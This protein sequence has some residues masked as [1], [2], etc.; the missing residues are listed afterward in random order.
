MAKQNFDFEKLEDNTSIFED[1]L[2]RLD[3]DSF[4][5]SKKSNKEQKD[6]KEETEEDD[7]VTSVVSQR[8]SG[9]SDLKKFVE[10][11]KFYKSIKGF[12]KD[13]S[14]STVSMSIGKRNFDMISSL[15]TILSAEF[16]FSKA[17]ITNMIL[18]SFFSKF[19]NELNEARILSNDIK[20]FS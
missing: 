1:R 10:S 14:E 3:E 6:V 15:T 20:A 4:S 9:D 12:S 2:K 8:R 11:S 7:D 19:A 13:K 18:S 5:K 17:D 16:G